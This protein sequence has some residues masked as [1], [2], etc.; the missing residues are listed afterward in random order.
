MVAPAQEFRLSTPA[1]ASQQHARVQIDHCLQ[2]AAAASEATTI[3]RTLKKIVNGVEF[4][5]T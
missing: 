4:R 5:R 2:L 1:F 3:G